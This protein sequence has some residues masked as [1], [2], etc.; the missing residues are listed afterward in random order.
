MVK[1]DGQFKITGYNHEIYIPF[2]SLDVLFL[3]GWMCC[4]LF[5]LGMAPSFL[6]NRRL[7]HWSHQ[8]LTV[9]LTHL[10]FKGLL[11]P[12]QRY[13][14]FHIVCSAIV[15]MGC[16]TLF[17]PQ[18][19]KMCCF[20]THFNYQGN[21]LSGP[22][23]H[24]YSTQVIATSPNMEI[25][26]TEQPRVVQQLQCSPR[27]LPVRVAAMSKILVTITFPNQLMAFIRYVILMTFLNILLVT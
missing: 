26:S 9:N 15:G 10:L 17:C 8:K 6:L 19:K 25:E 1:E 2:C 11:L 18:K 27:P 3:K 20:L 5:F 23:E 7:M 12:I 24:S 21:S 13:L 4:D 16:V 22:K 14:W